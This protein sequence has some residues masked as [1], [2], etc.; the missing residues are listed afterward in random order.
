MLGKTEGRRRRRQQD[1]MVGWYRQLDG[2]EF[3]QALEL[4]IDREACRALRRPWDLK[5]LDTTEQL[6]LW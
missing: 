5:E 6:N 1:E 2:Y 3:E 4:V